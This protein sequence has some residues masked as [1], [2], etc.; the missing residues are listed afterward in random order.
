M[1]VETAPVRGTYDELVDAAEDI[2]GILCAKASNQLD[3]TPALERWLVDVLEQ[4]AAA[5]G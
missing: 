3:L 5:L 1:Q 4:I 2:D